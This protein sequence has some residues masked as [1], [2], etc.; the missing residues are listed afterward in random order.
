MGDVSFCQRSFSGQEDCGG[1][2]SGHTHLW[3]VCQLVAEAGAN[4]DQV[5]V[6]VEI[7]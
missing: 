2:Y 3:I 6:G 4:A 7:L 1:L 5:V